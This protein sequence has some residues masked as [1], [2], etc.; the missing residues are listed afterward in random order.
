MFNNIPEEM[1][2]YLQWVCWR[3]EDNGS[4]KP[5]KKVPYSP[6]L[7]KRASVTDPTTWTS[8]DE[9][10]AAAQNFNG[11]GFVLTENDPFSCIDLDV[12]EGKQPTAEQQA[13][14]KEFD[15]YAELSPSGR[16]SHVWIKG[17]VPTG[18]KQGNV[19]IYPSGRF[20][21]V[22][23][24][25]TRPGPIVDHSAKLQTMWASMGGSTS[26]TA[27]EALDGPETLSDEAIIEQARK[28]VNGAKFAELYAGKWQ[29]MY[30]SQSEADQSLI[31]IIQYYTKNKAQIIRVFHSSELGKRDKA[32]RHDYLSKMIGNSFDNELPPIN[33]APLIQAMGEKLGFV[34]P[35]VR[36]L[37][38]APISVAEWGFSRISPDVIVDNYLFADVGIL[39]APG[40][41]G[42]TTLVIYEAICIA[43][44]FDLYGR[45]IRKPGKV[46][47]VSAEDSREQII[48]RLTRIASSMRLAF[49]QIELLKSNILIEYVGGDN[50]RL[51]SMAG[52]VVTNSPHVDR[53]IDA[54][55]LLNPSLL[56][57]DPAVSF[58]V[59]ESRVN[60][61]EQGLIR[62][63][64]RIR[65]AVGCCVRLVHHT[66]KQNGRDGAIDQYAGRG[67]SAMADG[68][69]M[70]AVLKRMIPEE[71]QRETGEVLAEGADGLLLAL[72]KLSYVPLQP[73]IYL[74]R[75]GFSYRHVLP[76]IQTIEDKCATIDS[77]VI[78]FLKTEEAKGIFHYKK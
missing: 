56:V 62:A 50:F 6:R 18:K 71:W 72:P 51:C 64:R 55:K 23:G 26:Q 41:V 42:K 60:D 13:I 58:G 57:I 1:R 39:I 34:V 17:K 35:E 46:I 49:E 33:I 3:Y 37:S 32:K 76:S 24:N 63:A 52:D 5:S 40:G 38:F 54:I 8:F 21:T 66:G 9:A 47:I 75:N 77:K 10:T 2:N 70:V 15:S 67:G 12:E 19:E 69:R 73:H 45:I 44:G 59:G 31:N 28:A 11:I 65:D 20:M 16:G 4:S 43:L 48:A 25:T 78:E 7:G 14:Y 36:P 74:E 27:Q 68:A 30:P 22:T 53:L 29:D 61:A